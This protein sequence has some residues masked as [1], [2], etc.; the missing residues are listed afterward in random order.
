MKKIIIMMGLGIMAHVAVVAQNVNNSIPDNSI[1]NPNSSGN[2]ANIP[3]NTNCGYINPNYDHSPTYT[4][5]S[6]CNTTN[7]T[8]QVLPIDNAPVNNNNNNNTMSPFNTV[9]PY[10]NTSPYYSPPHTDAPLNNT[11]PEK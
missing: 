8:P 7:Q 5:T 4:Q 11:P 6:N 1:N 10:D 3:S 2:N 9:S